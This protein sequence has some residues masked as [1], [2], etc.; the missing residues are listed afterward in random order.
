MD[1]FLD[2]HS[3]IPLGEQLQTQLRL[4]IERGDLEREALLPTVKELA[5][6]LE[7]NY[8]TVAAAYRAL[9]REGYLVQN[10]RAGTRVAA[11]PPSRPEQAMVSQLSQSFAQQLTSLGLDINESLKLVAAQAQQAQ[12]SPGLKMAVLAKTPLE[13]Q[14]LAE[15]LRA[16]LTDNFQCVPLTLDTYQSLDYHFTVIDPALI[17]RLTA[18]PNVIPPLSTGLYSPDFPAGAD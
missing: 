13:A 10:R 15:R 17:Q 1:I 2:K 18:T 5:A 9:E 4:L 12:A 3:V 7:L 14:Q 16:F 8:N 11:K 6:Q